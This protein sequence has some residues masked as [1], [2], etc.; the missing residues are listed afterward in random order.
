MEHRPR[1]IATLADFKSSTFVEGYLSLT[2]IAICSWHVWPRA[3]LALEVSALMTLP[4]VDA[5]TKTRLD[6]VR[7][8]LHQ[9]EEVLEDPSAWPVT[10]C[11]E[12]LISQWAGAV[13]QADTSAGSAEPGAEMRLLECRNP[14]QSKPNV[15]FSL[16]WSKAISR[17]A[18]SL[19]AW[20]SLP[21]SSG[22]RG[23]LLW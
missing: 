2:N 12:Q 7:A 14:K 23:L 13:F 5:G 19:Q 11:I 9:H 4:G 1:R 15:R 17:V 20:P 8:F 16:M 22:L 10:H 18:F 21:F 3:P 6:E